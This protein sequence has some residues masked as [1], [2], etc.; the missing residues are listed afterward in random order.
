MCVVTCDLDNGC[1]HISKDWGCGVKFTNAGPL[2]VFG[3]YFTA[4]DRVPNPGDNLGLKVQV[5][6]AADGGGRLTEIM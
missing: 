1:K 5:M 2:G 3:F 4:A 6:P